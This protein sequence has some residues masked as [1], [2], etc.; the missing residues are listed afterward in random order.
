MAIQFLVGPGLRIVGVSHSDKAQGRNPLDE[1][2]PDAE[3]STY[4][5]HKNIN[6]QKYM[7]SMT[8]EPAFPAFEL[9]YNEAIW[10]ANTAI[11]MSQED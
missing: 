4:T 11:G 6:R 5:T 10:C 8:F 3:T 7:S 1:T 9:P 2:R